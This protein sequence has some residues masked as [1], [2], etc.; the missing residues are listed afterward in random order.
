MARYGLAEKCV[1]THLKMH[2]SLAD[3]RQ[4][5]SSKRRSSSN[6]AGRGGIQNQSQHQNKGTAIFFD[7][8]AFTKR[9]DWLF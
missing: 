6:R 1:Y 2:L 3:K 8:I 7:L 9:Q 4:K 5:S